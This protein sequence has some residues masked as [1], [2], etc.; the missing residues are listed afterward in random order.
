M[1]KLAMLLGLAFASMTCGAACGG[2]DATSAPS[3]ASGDAPVDA[4]VDTPLGET[5]SD[6]PLDETSSDAPLGDAGPDAPAN[7]CVDAAPLTP[8]GTDDVTYS[9]HTTYRCVR[10]KDHLCRANPLRKNLAGLLRCDAIEGGYYWPLGSMAFHVVGRQ[11]GKC[12]LD[13]LRE[14]EGGADFFRCELPLPMVAWAGLASP[15]TGLEVDDPLKGI[16]E[17]CTKRYSCSLLTGGPNECAKLD[18]RPPFCGDY[19]SSGLSDP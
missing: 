13:L 4:P 16:E 14:V 6:A 8:V 17:R 18:P 3:D 10:E 12:V 9:T 1:D 2:G 7:A 11:G 15:A 5:S 19:E